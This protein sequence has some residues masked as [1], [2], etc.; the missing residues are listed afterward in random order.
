MARKMPATAHSGTQGET[1]TAPTRAIDHRYDHR[2]DAYYPQCPVRDARP[3]RSA[4]HLVERMGPNSEPDGE[5]SQ[6][7][8][9]DEP[10]ELGGEGGTDGDVR[11]MPQRVG[12]MKQGHEVP[13]D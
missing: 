1:T 9:E 5:C 6:S 2:P 8:P 13:G 12:D 4:L 10:I 3:Q 7:A 11:Q